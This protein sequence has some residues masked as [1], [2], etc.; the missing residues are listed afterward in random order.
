MK[1]VPFAN[2][3]AFVSG[4]ISIVCLLGVVFAKGAFIAIVNS[5]FHGIDLAALPVKQ[6]TLPSAIMGFITIVVVTWLLG[7][8][9]AYC[10]NWCVKKFA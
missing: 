10:Y 8:L 5:F 2:A 9:F 7:Y 1:E 6:V 4:V 3:L